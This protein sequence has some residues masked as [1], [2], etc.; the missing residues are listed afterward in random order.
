MTLYESF[1]RKDTHLSFSTKKNEG[2]KRKKKDPI[3][4]SLTPS[5]RPMPNAQEQ[6]DRIVKGNRKSP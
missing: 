2:K 4:S 3:E 6:K 1:L 5:R